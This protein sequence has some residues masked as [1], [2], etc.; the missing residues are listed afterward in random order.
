MANITT[1]LKCQKYHRCK[2]IHG[3]NPDVFNM[4]RC[5]VLSVPSFIIGAS[6]NI[7][8]GNET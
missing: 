2:E 7:M 3:H 1:V 8:A 4:A 5:E 6:S